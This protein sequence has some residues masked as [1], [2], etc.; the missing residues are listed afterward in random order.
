[1][2]RV[3]AAI[4]R[5]STVFAYIAMALFVG[6]VGDMIYEVVSRRVFATPTLWAYDLAYMSNGAVFLLAGGFTLLANEHIRIDFLSTRLPR[7]LQDGLNS[8]VYI[9]LFLP[10]MAYAS[11]TAIGAAWTALI[12]NEAEPASP[13]QPLIWPFYA[14]IALGLC[15]FFL[16]ALAQ[17]IRHAVAA[18]GRG[19]S[20]LDR[21]AGAT[22]ESV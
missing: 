4:D 1:M 18:A 11:T 2:G 22:T 17:A 15:I 13:W 10:V 21:P 12:T 14:A 9:C 5:L 3:L 7:R 20:P 8:A 6:I 16:Q 19:P